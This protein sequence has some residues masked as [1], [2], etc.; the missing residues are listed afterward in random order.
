M[1]ETWINEQ[2]KQKTKTNKQQQHVFVLTWDNI[3]FETLKSMLISFANIIPCESIK[4]SV[5]SG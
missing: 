5:T 1:S 4:V 3:K 2:K